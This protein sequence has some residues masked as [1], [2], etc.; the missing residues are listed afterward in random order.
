[1]VEMLVGVVQVPRPVAGIIETKLLVL[2][3]MISSLLIVVA[4][5]IDGDPADSAR[6]DVCPR[7]FDWRSPSILVKRSRMSLSPASNLIPG[8]RYIHS[9]PSSVQSLH[10]GFVPSHLDFR[11]RHIS[12]WV[13]SVSKERNNLD[14]FTY[15]N[16]RPA[17]WIIDAR[18]GASPLQRIDSIVACIVIVAVSISISIRVSVSI[19]ASIRLVSAVQ[20]A[21]NLLSVS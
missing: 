18:I 6:L 4:P 19:C 20:A 3:I 15:S 8:S 21:D 16:G 2:C 17:P 14:G 10:L 7:R 5:L 12:H 13:E 11:D 1:M 9:A